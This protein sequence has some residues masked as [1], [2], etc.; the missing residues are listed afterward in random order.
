MINHAP[1]FYIVSVFH[2]VPTVKP[3]MITYIFY[4]AGELI[5]DYIYIFV[6][7]GEL[8]LNYISTITYIFVGA[9]ELI[10]NYICTITYI[11]TK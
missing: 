2:A 6:G 11:I 9:E 7:A 4:L 3:I 1:V 5:F 8:I 10:S